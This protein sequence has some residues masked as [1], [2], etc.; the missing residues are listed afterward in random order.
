MTDLAQLDFRDL[1]TA[2]QLAA[3]PPFEHRI[4]GGDGEL[5]SVN[6]LVATVSEGGVA[7]GAFDG[8]TIVGAVYGF[9]TREP[10]VLHSHYMAVDPAFR[11]LGLGVE[12]KAR[13][14]MWCLERGITHMRWTY[15]PLQLGNAH[16]NLHVLGATGVAYHVDH[17]GTLGGING[18]LPSDRVTVLWDLRDGATK[19]AGEL[20]VDVGPA[21]AD[22]IATSAPAALSAR[23]ALRAE[24]DDRLRDGWVLV[25]VDR[26][27]RQYSLARSG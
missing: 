1:T 8:D 17:Y 24:L 12:L 2:D 14:R 15:D 19:P 13:Q 20:V 27:T 6:M 23:F 9:A 10:H 25:D 18:S 7:I 3:L 16:L 26:S 11:R 5:V 22:D 21:S 4:W